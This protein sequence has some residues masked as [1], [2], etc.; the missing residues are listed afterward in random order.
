[1]CRHGKGG[2]DMLKGYG[3][4]AAELEQAELKKKK[5]EKL[6][7]ILLPFTVN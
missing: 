4:R 3:Q 5:K 2:K 7:K 1:M 6:K